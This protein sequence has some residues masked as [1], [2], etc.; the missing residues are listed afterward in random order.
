M[1]YYKV[2][3]VYVISQPKGNGSVR[4]T[5]TGG[6]AKLQRSGGKCI[7]GV[8]NVMV[9]PAY[10]GFIG[11][12]PAVGEEGVHFGLAEVIACY[13]VFAFSAQMQIPPIH[14]LCIFCKCL[15][16]GDYNCAGDNAGTQ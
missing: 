10:G 11:P 12:D 8:F 9:F 1:L 6:E 2:G 16:P 4:S 13:S 15:A 7:K 5:C 14:G 3:F